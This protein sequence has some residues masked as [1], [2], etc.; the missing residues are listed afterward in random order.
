[1]QPTV[2]Y[3]RRGAGSGNSAVGLRPSS[4]RV[5]AIANR[6][7]SR[8]ALVWARSFLYAGASATLLLVASLFTEYWYLSFIALT[9]FLF[10]ISRADRGEALR[11]GLLLGLVY[12]GIRAADFAIDEPLY[13]VG[14]WA[15]GTGVLALFAWIVGVAKEARGF[16]PLLIAF[17][18]VILELGLMRLGHVRGV[19]AEMAFESGCLHKA[20]ILLGFLTVSFVIVLFNSILIAAFNAVASLAGARPAVG[21]GTKERWDLRPF[22]RLVPQRLY[23]A[24]E[25]RAPP[26]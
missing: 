7:G 11:L 23:L 8:R 25:S 13:A 10:R 2:S 12:F 6:S 20:A 22:R 17:L 19:F 24:S 14:L 9:P 5:R 3:P 18:W 15:F 4:A 26:G 1:M 21:S 16:N